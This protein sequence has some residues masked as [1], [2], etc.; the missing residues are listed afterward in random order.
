[1]NTHTNRTHPVLMKWCRELSFLSI[2][3]WDNDIRFPN[4]GLKP[5]IYISGWH[6]AWFVKH[7][8]QSRPY[9]YKFHCS[10]KTIELCFINTWPVK[11]GSHRRISRL[12]STGVGRNSTSVCIF[13]YYNNSSGHVWRSKV[14]HLNTAMLYSSIRSI[15]NVRSLTGQHPITAS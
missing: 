8:I 4:Y 12:R 11:G 14:K 7:S 2:Q 15:V 1:M 5:C 10:R 9:N 3:L 6:Y 13:I